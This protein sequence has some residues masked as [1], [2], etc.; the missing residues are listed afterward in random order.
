MSDEFVERRK[1][2]VKRWLYGLSK[3]ATAITA[4]LTLLVMV[5]PV[6]PESFWLATRGWTESHFGQKVDLGYEKDLN[7]DIAHYNKQICY[8]THTQYDVD[9]LADRLEQFY[10]HKN[11]R[12]QYDGASQAEICHKLRVPYSG[13]NNG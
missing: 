11:H 9:T 2:P 1:S 3:Q 7:T 6:I 12:H 5:L 13:G 8:G 10:E 4:V